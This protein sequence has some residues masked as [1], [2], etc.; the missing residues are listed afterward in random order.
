VTALS[1]IF[2]EID[3][4]L[5]AVDGVRS[6]EREP[7][8]DPA[9]FPALE[10]LDGGDE[11]DPEEGE[12]GADRMRLG[13]TV[14]GYVEGSSG[15]AAHDALNALHAA[16]VFAL[17][18]DP[19]FNLGGLV[20]SIARSGGR[21]IDVAELSSKRRLGFAQDFEITYATPRGNPGTLL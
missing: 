8:G 1:I 3:V 11:P 21:R 15:A 4:R 7:S 9:R 17:C 16:A 12:V 6:Y 20:E 13:F 2:A 19:G 18:G 10:A 14:R 5:L